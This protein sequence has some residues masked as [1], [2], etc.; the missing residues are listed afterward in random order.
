MLDLG[1][2]GEELGV[3]TVRSN[4]LRLQATSCID[5]YVC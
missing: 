2:V 5:D 4:I 1:R 3:L